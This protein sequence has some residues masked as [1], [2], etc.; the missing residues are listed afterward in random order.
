MSLRPSREGWVDGLLEAARRDSRVVL[1]DADISRSVG[2]SRFRDEFPSRWVNVGISEQDMLAEAAGMALAG[3]VPFVESYAVFAAGRA[4]EHVR[5]SVCHMRLPVKIGGAHAGL[6]AGPDGATHQALEDIEIM[7]VLPGMTVLVP[8]DAGQAEAAALSALETS[9]PC[10][11]RFGRNPVPEIFP[12]GCRL[13]P[14]G[15][16]VMEEGGDVLIVSSGA[17]LQACLDAHARLRREGIAAAVVNVWS[18][19]PF[20]A[21]LVR[22]LAAEAGC[23][24]A[25]CD[26]QCAGG[27][28]GALAE[29]LVQGCPVPALPVCVNDSFGTSGEPEDLFALHGLGAD[30]IVESAREAMKRAGRS[31]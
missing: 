17:C 15:A 12:R 3:L 9:G 25:V 19:K 11:V 10:Y 27:L 20:P 6:S 7:R 21:E 22:S 26:H 31:H 29:A 24:I 5:T 14:G 13:G 8:A 23:A 16:D 28:F 4:W 2:S 30:S 1:I 18:I